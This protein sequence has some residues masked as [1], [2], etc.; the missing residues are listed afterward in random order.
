MKIVQKGTVALNMLIG[1]AK[2]FESPTEK[3]I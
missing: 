3:G 1:D 2:K